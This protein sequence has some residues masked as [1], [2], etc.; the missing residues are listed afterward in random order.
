MLLVSCKGKITNIKIT[1]TG[2]YKSYKS[3]ISYRAFPDDDHKEDSAFIYMPFSFKLDNDTGRDLII[4]HIWN[5]FSSGSYL[6]SIIDNKY[7]DDRH[8]GIKLNSGN[9]IAITMFVHLPV[10]VN[11]LDK[12]HSE[13]YLDMF[14]KRKIDSI[15]VNKFNP[16]LQKVIDSLLKKKEIAIYYDENKSRT[17]GF[18]A[19]YCVNK[20][21]LAIFKMDSIVNLKDGFKY[22]CD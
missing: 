14:R 19:S 1:P 15:V 12:S 4:S 2:N 20:K 13:R 3:F 6:P 21:V 17:A 18:M 7:Y 8:I 11:V 16:K 9:S 22:N 5:N 10:A